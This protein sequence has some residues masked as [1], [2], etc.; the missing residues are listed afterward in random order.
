MIELASSSINDEAVHTLV[1]KLLGRIDMLRDEKRQV[2]QVLIRE[3]DEKMRLRDE[4]LSHKEGS[5]Q[6]EDSSRYEDEEHYHKKQKEREYERL[7]LDDYEDRDLRS[8]QSRPADSPHE[9]SER[10]IWPL[11][12]SSSSRQSSH[13]VLSLAPLADQARE[14]SPPHFLSPVTDY[15]PHDKHQWEWIPVA[16][17]SREDE[18]RHDRG[19]KERS[20]R[21]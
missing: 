7:P 11:P 20:Q 1:E 8:Y 9:T 17:S 5:R 2:E 16:S 21:C 10:N 15:H 6:R 14:R 19:H 3:E 12:S 13:P 18:A 4:I